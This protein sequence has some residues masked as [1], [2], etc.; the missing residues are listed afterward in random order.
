MAAA[1]SDHTNL[2]IAELIVGRKYRITHRK[3]GGSKEG[4]YLGPKEDGNSAEFDLGMYKRTFSKDNWKF[5]E[6]PLENYGPVAA[7]LGRHR[8]TQRLHR[9]QSRRSCRRA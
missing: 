1:A 6:I 5:K 4:K 3:H 8:K 2:P 9:K 7:G